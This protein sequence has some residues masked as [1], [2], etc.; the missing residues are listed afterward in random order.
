MP[1]PPK[2]KPFRRKCVGFLRKLA[3]A[4]RQARD[5]TGAAR[6][7]FRRASAVNRASVHFLNHSRFPSRRGI[8][9][10]VPQKSGVAQKQRSRIEC[11]GTA[12]R[13]HDTL[14][15]QDASV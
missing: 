12:R 13:G 6:N 3:P 2:R 9:A 10:I 11:L 4:A 1:A 7:I 8:A 15:R 14:A 5:L